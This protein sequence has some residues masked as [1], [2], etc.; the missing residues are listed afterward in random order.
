MPVRYEFGEFNLLPEQR[1]VLRNGLEVPLGARAFDLLTCLIFRRD[2]VVSKNELLEL[3]WPGLV[4]TENNLNAQIMA[5]RKAFGPRVA[6]TVAGRGFRFGPPAALFG[7][8]SSDGLDRRQR[9]SLLGEAETGSPLSPVDELPLPDKPSIVVL[10]FANMGGGLPEDFAD[11]ITEDITTE[12]SRF[13]SLFVIARCSG[14]TFKGQAVDVRT[15]A[16]Q[17]GVRYVLEGSV[18][19][20]GPRVRVTAQLIDATTG[21]H[22]WA[23]KY[24][25]VVADAFDAQEELTKCIVSA[26]APQIAESEGGKA[27]GARPGNLNAHGLAL[28]SSAI[29]HAQG[30]SGDR[31]A[32]DEA[33][34]LAREALGLDPH[35]GFAW[36]AL[37]GAQWL[38]IYF[39]QSPSAPEALAEALDAS[40]RAITL[41]A[42]D[43][44]ARTI[45]GLL[46]FMA[47][48]PAA[49]L[50]NLRRAHEINPNDAYT[51]CWLAF[52]EATWG[53]AD[54]AEAHGLDALRRSPRD[55]MR[56]GFLLLMSGVYFSTADYV[57]GLQYAQ[58]AMLEGNHAAGPCV[59]LAINSVGLRD[60]ESAKAAFSRAQQLAPR[61]VA[62]RLAGV[63]PSPGSDYH[64][65]AHLFFRI[66]AG[67]EVASAAAPSSPN[68]KN[69]S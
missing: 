31:A 37:A 26:M 39:N 61:L 12:L 40:A 6:L 59:A 48:Q 38:R 10:P 43:H 50:E 49:G 36:R 2:R 15:V 62:A 46:S 58:R 14:F 24:D 27:R 60:I 63:W 51:L 42:T 17:L 65:R 13:R 68:R 1:Q 21:I 19:H 54:K 3:V 55:P 35:S 45:N 9:K 23:E 47:N 33:L 64:R 28:R 30:M 41:D 22:L 20:S 11:G 69:S 7:A 8:A 25:R 34:R 5:L 18:R 16:R 32:F 56:H 66:A 4:V 29:Q 52:Y 57:N 53:D 67:L 44:F